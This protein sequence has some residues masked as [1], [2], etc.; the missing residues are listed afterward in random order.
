MDPAP[1]L[2][3]NLHTNSGAQGIA[4]AALE[5]DIESD[6]IVVLDTTTSEGQLAELQ[7]DIRPIWPGRP[8]EYIAAKEAWLEV[9]AWLD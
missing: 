1:P 5:L 3:P 6:T 2:S 8:E 9:E 7:A 4:Q